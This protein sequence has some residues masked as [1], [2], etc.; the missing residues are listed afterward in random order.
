MP[1][2]KAVGEDGQPSSV[3]PEVRSPHPLARTQR[4]MPASAKEAVAER[5]FEAV[6]F[7]WDGTAVPDRGAD[8]AA[9]RARVE[10]LCAAGVHLFV[11]SGTHVGN[12]DRQLQARPTG[13]GWLHLCLN[14]GSEVFQVRSD[15]PELW[16][17]RS[18]SVEE[19][20]ALDRAGRLL[21]E[22]LGAR[23]LGVRVVPLRLNRRK[24]DLIPEPAWADTPK[25]RIGELLGA[26]TER[27]NAAGF[28][29]LSEVVALALS[30]ARTA[31][32]DNPRVTSDG[33]HVEIGLTDKSDSARWAA[34]WLA[35]RG[36]TGRLILVGGDEFGSV[37]A[38]PGSD[39]Y[40]LVPELARALFVSVGAEPG[41]VPPGVVHAA[42]GPAQFLGLLDAQ[43]ARRR[44][45]RVP[46]IDD[47]PTWV[48]ALPEQRA[49][50]RAAEAIGT[51]ANG[52]AGIR[53]AREEDGPNTAPLFAV[54]GIYTSG[55]A[56]RLLPGPL[57][58]D[59]RVRAG[60]RD[61]RLVDLRTGV[62]ARTSHDASR[63]STLRFVSVAHPD[64]LALRAEGSASYLESGATFAAAEDDVGLER[65][66]R[67]EVRLARTADRGGGGITVAA[68]D[69]QQITGDTRVVERLA[70]W[71]ADRSQ[72]PAWEQAAAGLAGVE[73]LGFDRLLAAH[74]EAWA[75]LWADAEIKIDGDAE[76]E[77]AAR[78]ATFHLLGVAPENGE[79][80]VGA[81]G[82]TGPAYGG[83]VFWDADVFVLPDLA[84]IRPA[85]A[86]SMLEYRVR[87]LPAARAAAAAEGLVGAR[88]PWESA[89]DGT[90][91]TPRSARG[92]KGEL[93]P[94]RTGEREAHI[95][96]AVAWGACE[97]VAWT[98]DTEF[99]EGPGRE[100]ILDTA[101]YWASRARVD[102][103]GRAHLRGVMGPDEYHEVVDDNAYTNVM[104]RWNLRQAARLVD[105]MG[106]DTAE[107]D[108]WRRLA[109]SLVD[110][111]DPVRG[112]YEQF[113]G[114][115]GLEPLL[116][117]DVADT[118]VAADILLGA[119]RV[120]GS[121]LIKQ[122]DVV[123][124]H[125]LVPDEVAAGSLAANLAFYEPRTAHGSSLSLAVHA[126]LFARA[127][128][129]DRALKLFR[130]AA[131]LDL[132]DL[133]GTTAGGLHLAAMGGLWRA[134]ACGFLGMRPY[135][136]LLCIDPCLPDAWEALT[137]GFRFRGDRLRVR[138][139]REAVTIDCTR[140]LH[141]R[142]A[143]GPPEL[144]VPPAATFSLER[145]DT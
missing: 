28:A 105:Q 20:A 116:V 131:R 97:Y 12:I 32:L 8:G 29:G 138:A 128:E 3:E 27:L 26:V 65:E 98:G 14:R 76:T 1:A 92:H 82:L 136:E 123:M 89:N 129:P 88:F 86:R 45:R 137:L 67:G 13:P 72:P 15:G 140:P 24:I 34:S 126:A 38:V 115:W 104:A 47:D 25:A 79:A 48:I 113:A 109:E 94:I 19:Q 108:E 53:G 49:L 66:D 61:K 63:L 91:V 36:I 127:R 119:E 101:R 85:A 46:A 17:R 62:L 142:V 37:G 95:V 50:E 90:D 41:G 99:L 43:L 9:L 64:A 83:H 96:A 120:T 121:Q 144:I 107:A 22:Q 31:G 6:V 58:T 114:Y 135:G 71:V 78:F 44:D 33:K 5:T 73:R 122:A 56:Q 100:L 51:L 102:Q 118:P 2:G 134:L 125:Y 103:D 130:L 70:A 39:S 132:D 93:I 54:N 68:R 106:G 59:L 11:M 52:W 117:A 87:R 57:W 21:A 42:G 40:L 112:V 69:W 18:A 145:S 55:A 10:A 75:G 23:G 143:G 35:E 84:A 60:R 141:V 16:W 4:L 110:G 133:T 74:R 81:R 111:W 7:D 124:L 139:S 30:A 77:L 80:T